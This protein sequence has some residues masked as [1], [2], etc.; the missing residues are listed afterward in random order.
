M[1]GE[2]YVYFMIIK[3]IKARI[4]TMR[5]WWLKLYGE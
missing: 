5:E 1:A 4:S 3:W 2:E